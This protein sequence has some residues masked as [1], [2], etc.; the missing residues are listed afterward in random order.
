MFYFFFQEEIKEVFEGSCKLIPI[1]IVNQEC[2]KLADDFIPELIDTLASQMNPQV[3]CSVAGLCNNER[4]DRL[5]EQQDTELATSSP[6]PKM[7]TCQGC[8]TVV[9]ILENKFDGMSRDQVLQ[10][11]LQVSS[12]IM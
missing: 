10:S 5:I 3:V 12:V 11:L 4:I 1:K 2:I 9:E 6:K 7:N 8:H